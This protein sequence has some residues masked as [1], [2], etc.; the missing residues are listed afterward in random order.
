[1]ARHRQA[2]LTRPQDEHERFQAGQLNVPTSRS[3]RLAIE[4][5]ARDVHPLP[6]NPPAVTGST[7]GN[8]ALKSLISALRQLGLITD[9]TTE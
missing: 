7:E 9:Q 5:L 8:E 4:D 3:L 2:Q 6:A 1:M